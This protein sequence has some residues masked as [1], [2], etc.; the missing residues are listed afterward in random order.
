MLMI[1]LFLIG[2]L[3]LIVATFQDIKKGEIDNWIPFFF[4][5]V[6]LGLKLVYSGTFF[7]SGLIGLIPFV[8][9]GIVFFY[10][11]LF[12]GGDAKLMMAMGSII[13]LT[14][15]LT[16]LINFLAILILYVVIFALIRVTFQKKTFK[17]SFKEIRIAPV[18]LIT[19]LV[20][21]L[22]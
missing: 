20:Y 2:A 17:E 9:I 8:I 4:A 14:E 11:K 7:L 19:Y 12:E 5:F 16:F 6:I 21:F 3:F 18:F 10:G 15:S 1:I 22:I 13:P